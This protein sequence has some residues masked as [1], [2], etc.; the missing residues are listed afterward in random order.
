LQLLSDHDA[1][2][3]TMS[4]VSPAKAD[5]FSIKGQKAMVVDGN[6]VGV[7]VDAPS[8]MRMPHR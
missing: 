8:W 3:V 1:L 5:A 4:I 7:A 6:L 2:L